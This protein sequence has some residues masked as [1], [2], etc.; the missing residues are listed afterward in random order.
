MSNI[1]FSKIY[2]F[3][4]HEELKESLLDSIDLIVDHFNLDEKKDQQITN[5]F[6][7]DKSTIIFQE[8]FKPYAQKYL[9][10]FV[11]EHFEN[12]KEIKIE[13]LWFQRY[14]SKD[15][16]DWHTHPLSHFAFV[17]YLELPDSSI[18]TKF[19]GYEVNLKEG[20]IFIFPAFIPHTSPI[21]ETN[22]QKTVIAGNS[23]IID[24]YKE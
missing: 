4:E 7:K 9:D 3:E 18:G 13:A 21:N 10:R 19:K 15:F 12:A 20:D 2:R 8:K 14:L 22:T 17:Y 16:H 11:K 5:Y 1:P 23:S 6:K 24:C